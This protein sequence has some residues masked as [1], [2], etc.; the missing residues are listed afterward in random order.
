MPVWFVVNISQP[1]EERKAGEDVFGTA[2]RSEIQA[3][4]ILTPPYKY[5]IYEIKSNTLGTLSFVVNVVRQPNNL[6][7]TPVIK[8]GG[9]FPGKFLAIQPPFAV[10]EET[11]NEDLKISHL[12]LRSAIDRQFGGHIAQQ[13]SRRS[14]GSRTSFLKPRFPQLKRRGSGIR[15]VS[16]H[17]KRIDP[18]I[19]A[20]FSDH[21]QIEKVRFGR[22]LR[23]EMVQ[24]SQPTGVLSEQ[25]G[26]NFFRWADGG[27]GVVVFVLDAGCDP[28]H[29]IESHGTAVVGKV[30]GEM[31]GFA[32]GAEV[33]VASLY[34]GTE[35]DLYANTV[36][37][38]VDVLT[39]VYDY[40]IEHNLARRCVINMS[41]GY[42]DDLEEST[43]GYGWFVT[44]SQYLISQLTDIGCYIITASGNKGT[45]PVND[46][47][48]LHALSQHQTLKD[49]IVVVGGVDS[50]LKNRYQVS[51]FVRVAAPAIGIPCAFG[52]N[53]G[54]EP[55]SAAS[56]EDLNPYK[57]LRAFSGTSFATPVVSALI[58]CFISL[59]YKKPIDVL[60]FLAE[61][62]EITDRPTPAGA[63]ALVYSGITV[64]HWSPES[65][66]EILGVDFETGFA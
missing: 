61:N 29:P 62:R 37:Q 47:P 23:T 10:Y 24:I 25:L 2:F 8:I 65:Q 26:N 33:V 36:F 55:Y 3:L 48:A 17:R 58:A 54:Y 52:Y 35:E 20:S 49:R 43:P 57:F 21:G 15:R 32:Q 4:N 42:G 7:Y 51:P 44:L 38:M 9:K 1:I 39:Q 5:S 19:T 53:Q 14:P 40:V 46:F 11:K 12:D 27:K 50:S 16:Q 45:G 66:K 6:Y 31:T 30:V 60:Y 34:S 28:Q 41:V 56:P 59:G 63:P 18:G 64:A 13:N 22:R